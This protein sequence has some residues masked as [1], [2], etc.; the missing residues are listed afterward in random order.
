[1]LMFKDLVNIFSFLHCM[2]RFTIQLKFS[3][4]LLL[5]K[6]LVLFMYLLICIYNVGKLSTYYVLI[7]FCL[8]TLV[9]YQFI[10]PK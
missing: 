5:F 6:C 4:C 8:V 7:H 10:T 9:N 1:M 3:L 2:H